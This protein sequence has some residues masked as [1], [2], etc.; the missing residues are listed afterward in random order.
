MVVV[1]DGDGGV[2][3]V[4][5]GMTRLGHDLSEIWSAREVWTGFVRV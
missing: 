2:G 3:G 4:S 1:S 5:T